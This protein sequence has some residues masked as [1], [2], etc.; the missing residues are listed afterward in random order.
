MEPHIF[1]ISEV[2]FQS[3]CGSGANQSCIISG[4]SGAG[5]VNS[6]YATSI[7]IIYFANI[8]LFISLFS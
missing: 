6:H 2:A 3:L 5:K 8:K 7:F 4:E 1:A